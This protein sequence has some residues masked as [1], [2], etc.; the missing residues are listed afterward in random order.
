MR[1]KWW[2]WSMLV[3]KLKVIICILLKIQ[4]ITCSSYTSMLLTILVQVLVISWSSSY[5]PLACG[6][7]FLSW[8]MHAV[9][10]GECSNKHVL[11]CSPCKEGCMMPR[12]RQIDLIA[13]IVPTEC[14]YKRIIAQTHSENDRSLT[15]Y[16]HRPW[17]NVHVHHHKLHHSMCHFYSIYCTSVHVSTWTIMCIVQHHEQKEK[18]NREEGMKNHML[19]NPQQ[20]QQLSKV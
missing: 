17:H 6:T 18:E 3:K 4:R 8:A 5:K 15:G 19:L 9:Y 1:N 20:P 10:Y 16:Y 13:K 2:K 14:Q 11:H 12:M 7:P